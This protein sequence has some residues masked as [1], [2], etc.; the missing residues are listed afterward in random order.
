[1]IRFNAILFNFLKEYKKEALK[2]FLEKGYHINH[3]MIVL[4]SIPPPRTEADAKKGEKFLRL[5]LI[6]VMLS[7]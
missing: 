1:M 5:N 2:L 4:F 7:K 6:V 3:D